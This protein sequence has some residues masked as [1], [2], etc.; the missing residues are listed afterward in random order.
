MQTFSLTVVSVVSFVVFCGTHMDKH[1]R[2]A[3]IIKRCGCWRRF[4][5]FTE[6]FFS[7]LLLNFI[8]FCGSP[9]PKLGI[10]RGL[11]YTRWDVGC[12]QIAV[13]IAVHSINLMDILHAQTEPKKLYLR[14]KQI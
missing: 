1:I 3:D 4:I 5:T 8:A 13:E 6:I 2:S 11:R 12:D 14:D 7:F 10:F 9:L